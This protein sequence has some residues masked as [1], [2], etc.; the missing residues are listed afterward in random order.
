[1]LPRPRVSV[2]V[3]CR[4]AARTLPATLAAVAAQS[5]P[6]AEVIVVDD[7][8]DDD[9]AALAERL[10]ARVLRH[11]T[12]RNAGGAR[13]RALD[14]ATGEVLAFLDADAVPSTNWLERVAA[15]L[16]RDAS[17]VAVGGRIANG[18]PGRWG[19]LD[20]F[21][22]HSEWIG[23]AAGPRGTFPTMAVAYR[24]SAVGQSLP[25]P[26]TAR[27]RSSPVPCCAGAGCCGSTPKSSSPTVTSGSTAARSGGPPSTPAGSGTGPASTSTARDGRW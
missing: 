21:L 13:N 24:G 8:S 25:P 11:E 1:L 16:A 14:V 6:A 7:A 4:N 5:H 2:I 15:N 20:Y 22:N 19:D 3:P 18:R 23:G 10:G 27:T 9:S 12:R 26:I 17:I